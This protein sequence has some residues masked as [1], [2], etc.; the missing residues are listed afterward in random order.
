M[1]YFK[2][3]KGRCNRLRIAHGVLP[4]FIDRLV[5]LDELEPEVES[6]QNQTSTDQGVQVL[7]LDSVLSSIG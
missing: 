1:G 4:S 5:E 6:E 3:D 7:V 2:I